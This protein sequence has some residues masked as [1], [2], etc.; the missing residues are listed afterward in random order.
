[1]QF[2]DPQDWSFPVP[3]VYGP[4]RLAEIPSLCRRAGMKAP[5]IVTDRGSATLPFIAEIERLLE[6]SGLICAVHSDISPN[7]RDTEIARGREIFRAGGH[8]GV[9]AIGGGSGMDGGKAICLTATNSVD[10]WAFEYEQPAPD[11]AGQPPFAPLICIPTTA[12]TGAETESTTMVTDTARGMK[13]CVWHPDL[14]PSF[15]LLDPALTVGLPPHLTAWTGVDAMVHAIEAF[16]VPGFNP[17]CDGMGLEGLSLL[18]HWLPIAFREPDNL[19]ARGAML[20]GSCLAGV[21]LSQGA[22][23]GARH[24]AYGGGRV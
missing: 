6:I 19:D 14:K 24:L 11:M 16:C 18:S 7:P 10:L 1:M 22:G 20:A 15:A 5:L 2:Q 12:G 23:A 8:D 3:I 4:G 21:A 17:P 13:F 9:I